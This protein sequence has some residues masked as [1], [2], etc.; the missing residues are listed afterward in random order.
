MTEDTT[1][2]T[3]ASSKTPAEKVTMPDGRVVEF[4]GKRRMVKES[5]LAEGVNPQVRLD[6]RNGKSITFNIPD[7][8]LQRFAAHGAEQKLG[9]ETAGE[10]D[11]DDMYLG[12]EN[13]VKRL[14]AGE[15]SKERVGGGMSGTSVLIKALVEFSKQPTETDEQA[16]ERVKAFLADKKP[17]DKQALRNSSK[18]KPIVD[19]LEAEKA[20][21]TAHIDTDALLS[22]LG[23]VA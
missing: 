5:I 23:A 20:A 4:V 17:A 21:K 8:L 10:T 13:L 16:S 19:R 6:F 1:E 3:E 15:W 9:D 22:G 11:V 14:D 18:I 7:S 2:A 12:V